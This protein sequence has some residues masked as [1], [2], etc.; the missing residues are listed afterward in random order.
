SQKWGAVETTPN[1][2]IYDRT[3]QA[4]FPEERREVMAVRRLGETFS[5]TEGVPVV[6]VVDGVAGF[7]REA[8]RVT[9]TGGKLTRPCREGWAR[10]DL[11]RHATAVRAVYDPL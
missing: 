7:V 10:L 5:P 9:A 4:F 1:H 11:P 8:A 3:G 2:S 6:D